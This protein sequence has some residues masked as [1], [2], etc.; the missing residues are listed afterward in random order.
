MSV[1]DVDLKKVGKVFFLG[2]L[3][4]LLA[5]L[6]IWGAGSEWAQAMKIAIGPAVGWVAGNLAETGM[7]VP[8]VE[9]LRK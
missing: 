6:S 2:S 1:T 5:F 8:G 9:G 3:V 7:A 4:W